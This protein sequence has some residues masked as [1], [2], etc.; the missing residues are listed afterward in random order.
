MVLFETILAGQSVKVWTL[1]SSKG[2]AVRFS[3]MSLLI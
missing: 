3:L 1:G 2:Y